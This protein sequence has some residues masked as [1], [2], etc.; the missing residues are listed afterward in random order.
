MRLLDKV[1]MREQKLF[2]Q[3]INVVLPVLFVLAGGF[4]FWFFR[5]RHYSKQ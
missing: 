1:K 4:I 2:W 5:R 3:L